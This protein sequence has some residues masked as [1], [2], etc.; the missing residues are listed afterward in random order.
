M[1]RLISFC[2]FST[3]FLRLSFSALQ[4]LT[5]ALQ[6]ALDG[7]VALACPLAVRQIGLQ[8]PVSRLITI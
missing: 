8:P 6:I 1:V 4:F 3:L 2:N 5:S 7:F